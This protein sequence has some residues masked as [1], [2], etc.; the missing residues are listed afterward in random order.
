MLLGQVFYN[1]GLGIIMLPPT[2]EENI[3]SILLVFD[4]TL[5]IAIGLLA[6]GTGIALWA[7]ERGETL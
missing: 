1:S 6:L 3:F 7:F 2:I 5:W 4:P